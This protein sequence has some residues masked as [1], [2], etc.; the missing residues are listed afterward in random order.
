[1]IVYEVI[2]GVLIVVYLGRISYYAGKILN[3]LKENVE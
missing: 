2:F 1:M 3:L